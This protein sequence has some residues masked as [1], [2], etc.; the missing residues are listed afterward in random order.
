M[1]SLLSPACSSAELERLAWRIGVEV[2]APAAGDVDQ[3]ARFPLETVAAMRE[4]RLLA[5]LIPK[6]DGG[7]GFS[8]REMAGALRALAAH[9]PSSALVLA[10]HSV[11]VDT[12][13][14]HGKTPGLRA[15]LEEI[16]VTQLLIGNASSE[17]GLGGAAGRSLCALEQREGGLF[18]DKHVLAIS[19]GDH[20]DAVVATCRRAPES[21]ETDQVLVVRRRPAMQLT[22]TS[23]WNTSGLRGTCSNGYHLQ[24][25][26]EPDLVFPVPFATIAGQGAAQ[27][28]QLLLS[29][30]WVGIA[31]AAVMTAHRHVRRRARRAPGVLSLDATRVAELGVLLNKSRSLLQSACTWF[32]RVEGDHE[33]LESAAMMVALR[34]LKVG[35]SRLAAE[36]ASGALAICGIEGYRRDSESS[37]D[38]IIRDA[39]GGLVMVSNDRHLE[40]NAAVLRALKGA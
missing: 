18:L 21:A 39:H 10:M 27:V 25:P 4:E 34:N 40:D 12:L 38:R 23:T 9:C 37:L 2:A 33:A 29:A 13:L 11:E 3:R 7:L 8:V 28:R 24:S 32:E 6:A 16:A 5:A 15:L 20:A 1:D 26:V 36:A 17:V 31:E 14:R 22:A 35:T 19:Y 30:V